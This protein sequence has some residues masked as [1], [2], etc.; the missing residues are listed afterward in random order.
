MLP[1]Y[2]TKLA[3]LGILT[4]QYHRDLDEIIIFHKT[5]TTR[6]SIASNNFP[7][8]VQTITGGNSVK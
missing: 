5:H 7:K 6:I 4:L 8:K 1:S 3:T 2:H